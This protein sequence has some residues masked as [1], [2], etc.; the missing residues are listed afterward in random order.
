HPVD[1]PTRQARKMVEIGQL[2]KQIQTLE[3]GDEAARRQ[4]IQTLRGYEEKDWAAA[5]PEVLQPLVESLLHQLPTGAK[6]PFMPKEISIILG[7]MGP[8]S[9]S[10]VPQL[11]EF[12]NPEV[13]DSIREAVA[14]TL[15]KIGRD[16]KSAVEPLIT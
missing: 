13:P 11:V 1:S 8:R 15:G 12:L 5:S 9:Q 16:A 4:V 6:P 7:N 2:R 10:A 14:T 3:K